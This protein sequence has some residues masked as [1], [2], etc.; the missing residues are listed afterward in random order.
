[1]NSAVPC[2]YVSELICDVTIIGGQHII[3]DNSRLAAVVD[4]RL[5]VV[6]FPTAEAD[7][8]LPCL[9]RLTLANERI[10]RK[11]LVPKMFNLCRSS[12]CDYH[13]PTAT[14]KAINQ[15]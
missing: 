6:D 8:V 9:N 13:D 3:P 15:I 12:S 1:M 5:V 4:M 11:I 7:I 10:A 2:L 14:K